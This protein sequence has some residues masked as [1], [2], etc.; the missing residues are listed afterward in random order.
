MSNFFKNK[1]ISTFLIIL[2]II[3]LHITTILLPIE[4]LILFTLQPIQSITFFA[5]HNISLETSKITLRENLLDENKNLKQQINSLEQKLVK[6]RLF[7]EENNL[8][9]EQNKYLKSTNYN[10]INARVI[11][12]GVENNPNLLILNRGENDNIKAGMAVV[13]EQGTLVG[14]I[15]K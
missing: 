12:V 7:I 13:V 1:F 5:S 6:L 9:I 10:F 8:L 4:K 11:S 14:K 15:I 3:F 2:L